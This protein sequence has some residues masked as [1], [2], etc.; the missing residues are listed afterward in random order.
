[1]IVDLHTRVWESDA[2]LGEAVQEQMRR[3]RGHPWVWPDAST[4]AHDEAMTAAGCAVIHGFESKLLGAAIDPEKIAAWTRRHPTKYLGFVGIDPLA[5][6]APARLTHALD[7]GLVGLT[8]SPPAAGFHPAD[9]RAMA[10][11]E[12]CAAR[13]VPVYFE[14]LATA[15]RQVKMEFS[16]PHLLDEV[17]R[18]F[19][20]LKIVIS[21]VGQPWIDQGLALAGKHPTV[22]ADLSGLVRTP[23]QLYNVLLLAHQ[24]QTTSQILFASGFPFC[25]PA[26]AMVTIYSINTLIQGTA[27]PNVPREQLRG[28][29]ERDTLTCLGLKPPNPIPQAA[30]NVNVQN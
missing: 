17:A 1:M 6:D 14:S 28:I 5:E 7:L 27:L 13:G 18:A 3:R 24:Q 20:D 12:T 9:T 4:D 2:Q 26:D 10:L 23:W 22:Y 15:A 19:P 25:C 29:V 11:Y 21:S 30:P 8:L 16:Q